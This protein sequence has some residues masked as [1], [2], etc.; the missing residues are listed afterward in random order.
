MK[1]RGYCVAVVLLPGLLFASAA[2]A[3]GFADQYLDAALLGRPTATSDG[4]WLAVGTVEVPSYRHAA[5][6]KLDASGRPEWAS[7]VA[8]PG[9]QE[10]FAVAEVSDGYIVVGRH[11]D[12]PIMDPDGL[13]AK[14]D[15][16]G[17]IAWCRTDSVGLD[18]VW[19]S[20][21]ATSDGAVVMT[22]SKCNDDPALELT[23]MK[24]DA[25]GNQRWTTGYQRRLPGDAVGFADAGEIAATA[26][27][28]V[29]V[30]DKIAREPLAPGDANMDAL[31]M[32]LDANGVVA[33]QHAYGAV[34]PQ[35]E[36]I[37]ALLVASDGS[38]F[39]AGEQWVSG[40]SSLTPF[41]MRAASD[42]ELLWFRFLE[43]PGI[44]LSPMGLGE[45][46]GGGCLVAMR[47]VDSTTLT[48]ISESGDILWHEVMAGELFDKAVGGGGGLFMTG[49]GGLAARFDA[50][51]HAGSACVS[52][53][54]GTLNPTNEGVEDWIPTRA[55]GPVTH[56]LAVK[57]AS[58]LVLATTHDCPSCAPL[59][60]SGLRAGPAG[61]CPSGPFHLHVDI[62]G[63]ERPVVD[64]DVDGDGMADAA[65]NDV[66]VNL[67]PGM[68]TIAAHVQDACPYGVQECRLAMD[69][70]VAD[71]PPNPEVSDVLAGRPPL[72]LRASPDLLSVEWLP[73]AATYAAYVGAIG[74]WFEPMPSWGACRLQPTD[75]GDGTCSLEFHPDVDTWMVVTARNAC[76]EGPAG[77]TS[78]G[79]ERSTDPG[80][81]SCP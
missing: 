74:R 13:I 14:V 15:R 6:L 55:S 62:S 24:V 38:I 66:D 36:S 12:F 21:T 81:V 25:A 35:Y 67:P 4:G 47:G 44:V 18:C 34:H 10:V 5:L 65:G 33:W 37:G 2:R 31:L 41:V 23:V 45:R 56:S 19:H 28:G 42:G 51:G 80:W 75:L 11:D 69:V 22:G 72:R 32:K 7:A 29:I 54:P 1:V 61:P 50:N 9:L 39:A 79:V 40:G 76:S 52:P 64:W 77:R 17:G 63:G 68:S 60:C 70:E 8:V 48:A 3:Q 49:L 59:S 57:A 16:A 27:G 53:L 30:S 43:Q 78:L 26:D 73:G 71:P 58:L 20:A 46:P